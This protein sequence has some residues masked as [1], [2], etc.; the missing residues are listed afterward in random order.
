MKSAA[1]Y[2]FRTEKHTIPCWKWHPN[3]SSYIIIILCHFWS[4]DKKFAH[5][6]RKPNRITNC[7]CH[8][9]L[10]KP[11]LAGALLFLMYFTR[12][13]QP[14]SLIEQ[15]GKCVKTR[16]NKT[17]RHIPYP[18]LWAREHSGYHGLICHWS[19]LWGVTGFLRADLSPKQTA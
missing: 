13:K 15:S 5:L 11:L 6:K 1:V 3:L 12:H 18:L 16:E 10:N 4:A 19:G 7:L 14:P 2:V 17:M 8:A 9:Q